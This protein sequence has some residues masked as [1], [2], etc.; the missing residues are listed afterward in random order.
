MANGFTAKSINFKMV[1]SF[2]SEALWLL[3]QLQ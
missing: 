1:V 2:S 3:M